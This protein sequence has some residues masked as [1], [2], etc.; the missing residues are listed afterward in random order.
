LGFD[1]KTLADN[2]APAILARGLICALIAIGVAANAD[3]ATA[4]KKVRFYTT[5]G[6]VEVEL[7]GNESPLHVANFLN[8]V[9]AGTY[10]NS[11]FHRTRSQ[12]PAQPFG[13]DLFAQGGSYKVPST[14][15]IDSNPVI[16]TQ[17]PVPNEFNA[18]NGLS[19]TPGTLAA[20][21]TSN[22]NSATT[23]FFFNQSNNAN[24]FDPGPY[25]VFGKVTSG[26]NVIDA[27]PFMDN[28]EELIGTPF[29][30]TPVYS[31]GLV[32]LLR[33]GR[34]PLIPGDFDFSGAVNA[35]DYAVWR[36]NYG[37][38]TNAAADANGNGRVDNADYVIWRNSLTG[39]AT[40][41]EL[42]SGIV[43]EPASLFLLGLGG[44]FLAFHRRKRPK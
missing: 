43:P 31:G 41:A 33:I 12:N 29:E 34:I 36:S 42:Q 44:Y 9:D 28:A 5:I 14:S 19:N 40:A 1:L 15:F 39:S 37:S 7:Y 35:G 30:S 10:T 27:M 4:T 22:P 17:P 38:L 26:I 3:A 2:T 21:R 20:A 13:F 32:V 18:A 16:A 8:Y 25:T 24:S 6:S 11:F 23:G